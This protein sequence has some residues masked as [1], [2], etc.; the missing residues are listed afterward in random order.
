MKG[1][2]ILADTLGNSM[3][4]LDTAPEGVWASDFDLPLTGWADT[5]AEPQAG[6][7]RRRISTRASNATGSMTLHAGSS[8]K[9][10]FAG[11]IDDVQGLIV[12]MHQSGGTIEY[13]G[14]YNLGDVTWDVESIQISEWD[15]G[16]RRLRQGIAS[17]KISYEVRPFGR[18]D[19]IAIGGS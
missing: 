19:P 10:D 4:V 3:D 16:H 11:F 1:G 17:F 7:G 8:D 9:Q 6:E 18:M 15:P 13:E 5:W 12:R 14:P 2:L